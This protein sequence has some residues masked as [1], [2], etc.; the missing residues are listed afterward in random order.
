MT[1]NQKLNKLCNIRTDLGDDGSHIT[2]INNAIQAVADDFSD[3]IKSS[4]CSTLV[5]KIVALKEP[6]QGNDSYIINAKSCCQAEINNVCAAI[7][8]EKKK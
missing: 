6:Y 4:E 8:A 7:E 3:L 2:T 5:S 1:N